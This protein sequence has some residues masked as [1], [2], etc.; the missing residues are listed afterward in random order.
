MNEWV[1]PS[2][3][4]L[5]LALLFI[6]TLVP[7]MVVGI[8]GIGCLAASVV[9]GFHQYGPDTGVKL[10]LGEAVGLAVLFGIW[11]KYF[12]QSRLGQMLSLKNT[13][14]D[15][16]AQ[17]VRARLVGKHGTIVAACRP[18]GVAL[19]D[20]ERVDVVSEST[21]LEEGQNVTVTGVEGI[22]VIVRAK[23]SS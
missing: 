15:T 11:I 14:R 7:G 4:V 22:R 17:E 23:P 13:N 10:L 2:L 12:P 5:G 21:F 16:Q 8:L 6:E 3:I 9:V 19:I 18:A 20:G 1:I